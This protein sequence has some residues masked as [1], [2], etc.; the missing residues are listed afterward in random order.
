M[1]LIVGLG[2][3]GLEYAQTRHN[4]GWHV[5]DLLSEDLGAGRPAIKF[6]GQFWGP[7][8]W[9][10]HRI[11]LLKP[12]TYMNNSGVAVGELARFYRLESEQVLIVYDDVNLPVGRLR[13][14]A[15]GSAGGHNGMKSII[16]HLGTLDFPRLRVGVGAPP[17]GTAMVDYVLGRF[18]PE[19]RPV[20][21]KAIAAASDI[22]LEWCETETLRLMNKVNGYR[23]QARDGE[24]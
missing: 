3:P 14:R 23:A 24:A 20:V 18:G 5:L 7:L 13:L 21:D 17:L 10:D 4:V 15:H 11:C 2:N 9:R 19:D 16:A 22:C 8:C 6:G 1:R 12:L